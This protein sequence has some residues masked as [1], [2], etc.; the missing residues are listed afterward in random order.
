M[1][2]I[3]IG[4]E[5]AVLELPGRGARGTHARDV[6]RDVG[7]AAVL[8]FSDGVLERCSGGGGDCDHQFDR[9]SRWVRDSVCGGGACRAVCGSGGPGKR[10]TT[11]ARATSRGSSALCSRRVHR[12]HYAAVG[13]Q[14]PILRSSLSFPIRITAIVLWSMDLTPLAATR[15]SAPIK[16]NTCGSPQLLGQYAADPARWPTEADGPAFVYLLGLFTLF[17]Q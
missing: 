4:A 12:S 3:R 1:K 14:S 11:S 16:L 6:W 7:V 10:A 15:P 2:W 9:E 13:R 17:K 8:E 5:R